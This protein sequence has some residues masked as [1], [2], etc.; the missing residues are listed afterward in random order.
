[1]SNGGNKMQQKALCG[2]LVQMGIISEDDARVAQERADAS[3]GD[4][5][6]VLVAERL[7]GELPL[8]EA[9]CTHLSLPFIHVD[10]CHLEPET[11]AAVPSEL[12]K[13]HR[14]VV[15]DRFKGIVVLAAGGVL[16][17]EVIAEVERL[18]G[19][20]VQIC[21]TTV[22]EI[23]T[24]LENIDAVPAQTRQK[25]T[26]A[27]QAATALPSGAD[28]DARS[29]AALQEVLDTGLDEQ[30]ED[31][32]LDPGLLPSSPEEPAGTP[33]SMTKA[34]E[35][36]LLE[37]DEVAQ[38]ADELFADLQRDLERFGPVSSKDE[39]EQS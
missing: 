25:G 10:Q 36:A 22:S 28:P 32:L 2:I 18:T 24:V 15:V 20:K 3:D 9:I 39:D 1:M 13:R 12:Q 8:A 16:P 11:V 26:P 17:R 19:C 27:E 34:E 37:D 5:A 6:G 31:G 29:E 4:V 7:V 33:S 35:Q 14:F 30:P 21:A 23:Q 38:E